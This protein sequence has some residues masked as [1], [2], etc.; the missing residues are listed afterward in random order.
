MKPESDVR[1]S[2]WQLRGATVKPESNV[3]RAIS[4]VL[5][6]LFASCAAGQT[7]QSSGTVPDTLLKSRKQANL[8]ESSPYARWLN[9][10]VVYIITGAERDAFYKLV[11]DDEREMFVKQFWERRNPDPGSKE[12]TFKEEHY[13]RIAYVNSHFATNRPGWQTDLGRIYILFG[14]PDQIDASK[15]RSGPGTSVQD[16]KYRYIDGFGANVV[17]KFTDYVGDGDFRLEPGMQ[18]DVQR[19]MRR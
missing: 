7:S 12:N 18:P 17:F 15:S 4:A 3:R 16:W 6:C 19:F 14:P 8:P 9:E 11:T 5:L 1:C 10:E 13:R 2:E